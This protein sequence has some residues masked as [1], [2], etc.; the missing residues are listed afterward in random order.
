M[1]TLSLARMRVGSRPLR[2]GR[3]VQVVYVLAD[4]FFVNLNALL[5]YSFRF[6]ARDLHSSTVGK[7]FLVPNLASM[8]EYLGFLLVYY[9]F[10]IVLFC[11]YRNAYRT[12]R[13]RSTL[14]ES[15]TVLQSVVL[16]SVVIIAFI[17]FSKQDVSRLVVGFW[18]VLNVLTMAGWRLWKRNVVKRRVANG[19]GLRNVL[20]V[21]AGR[22]GQQLVRHFENNKHLGYVVKGF[23]D[24]NHFGDSRILGRIEDLSQIVRAQFVDEI[25]VTI[26]SQRELVKDV[27]FEAHTNRVD[28]KLIPDLYDGLAWRVPIE[29]LGDFPIMALHE[30]PI[31][32]LGLLIKRT[33]DIA[34]SL[35]GLVL[36]SPVLALIALA[37]K[38]DSPGPILY[39]SLRVGKKG[40]RFTCYKFRTM[41]PDA[42]ALKESL[43]PLNERQGPFFKIAHDPRLTRAGRFLRKYSLDELPQ[44]LNVL[45]G[46][47]SLVGPRPHPV[48][49]YQRYTLE[50]LRRLEVTPG[51]TGLFQIYARRDRSFEKNLAHDTEYIEKWNLWLDIKILL[52]TIPAVFGGDGE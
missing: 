41:V 30:R 27:V 29:Y 19:Y 16:A 1:H 5:V 7:F 51:I 20:I 49:D 8:R 10:L 23:V 33:M 18:A 25:F 36:F 45:K 47:M 39:P 12:P 35:V 42:D 15:L 3:W 4:I 13:D 26:P 17:Y 40:C 11:K 22:V 6:G 24:Q 2:G 46:D 44:L 28:V 50:H 14:D 34:F 21:G 9:T 32:A 43:R 37:I 38:L 31:P 48:D 52:K